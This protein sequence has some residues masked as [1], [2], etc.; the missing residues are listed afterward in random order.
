MW[1][2]SGHMDSK[3]FWK[4]YH[5]YF[6]MIGNFMEITPRI[7]THNCQSLHCSEE[8]RKNTCFLDGK[9]CQHKIPSK[10]KRLNYQKMKIQRKN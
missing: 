5:S 7:V 3:K 10:P 8:E 2:T 4:E 6:L 1:S 9:Y